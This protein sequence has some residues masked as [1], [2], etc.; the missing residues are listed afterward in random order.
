MHS[1]VDS[2]AMAKRKEATN[3]ASAIQPKGPPRHELGWS[4]LDS[5]RAI[6]IPKRPRSRPRPLRVPVPPRPMLLPP[7]KNP[8]IQPP[9]LKRPGSRP[10]PPSGA[11][12]AEANAAATE[13]E[14]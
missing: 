5:L 1:L 3:R 7:K 9:F 12:A 6:P 8:A 2:I 10:P 4:C 14:S 13:E 11:G